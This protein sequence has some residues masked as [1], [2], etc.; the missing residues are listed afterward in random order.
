MLTVSEIW[1]YP[2]KSCRG[3]LLP[4]VE[5]DK[6]GF[7]NDRRMM[8]VDEHFKYITQRTHPKMALI[9][10][11]IENK[12]LLIDASKMQQLT[13]PLD[14]KTGKIFETTIWEDQC[15]AIS[16]SEEANS[17]FSDYLNINCALVYMPESTNRIVDLAYNR[18]GAITS[19]TDGFP[20]LLATEASLDFLNQKLDV[21]MEM[22]RFRPNLVIAGSL[23]F[24]ED[25]WRLLEIADIKIHILKPCSRCIITTINPETAAKGAEPLL[26]LSEFRK[27]DNKI[28]FAQNAIHLNHSGWIH[29]GSTIEVLDFIASQN[30]KH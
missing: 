29:T 27:F 26:T 17:W 19:F 12:N 14:P 5:L 25:N 7:K 24:E 20:I 15:E 23:P 9:N 2:I 10:V 1:I 16:F 28:K 30:E 4:S 18:V 22:Q 8:L 6:L 11:K 21:K 3:I 13:I